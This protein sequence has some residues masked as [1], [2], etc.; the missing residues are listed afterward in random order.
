MKSR[1]LIALSISAATLGC[2][3]SGLTGDPG[4]RGIAPG[5]A[6]QAAQ[7][8]PDIVT[9]FGGAA[10]AQVSSYVRSVGQR[11][12][13]QTGIVTPFTV[14]TLNSPVLNAFAVP[15]GYVYFT[16]DLVALANDEAELASVI[17]HEMGHVA[18]DHAAERQQTSTLGGLGALLAGVIFGS[19]TATQLVGQVA[20]TYLLS[21]SRGQENESDALGVR[22]I[23]AAGYDPHASARFLTSLGAATTLDDQINGRDQRSVPNFARTHPL[24]QERVQ[25]TTTLA[26]QIQNP[27]NERGRDRHL[28]AIDGMIYGDDP[29]QGVIEGNQF[30]HPVL[31][32]RFAVPQGYTMQNGASA[33]SISGP[34]GQ[35]QFGGG[36][37]T[38]SLSS[39]ID[40][41]FRQLTGGQAQV[42][43]PAPRTTTVNGKQA[44][45]TTATLN[46]QQGQVDVTVFAYQWDSSTIYHFVTLTRAGSG[47]GPFSSMIGSLTPL[48][49]SE[50][51][52]IR[53][54]VI[55]IVTVR[56]GDTV[57]S[58]AGRMAYGNYQ[59]ERFLV[60]NGLSSNSQ[61]A[62]G[63][64]VKLVVYGN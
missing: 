22:Y 53:P 50:A 61:L 16:R 5:V 24:S 32:L 7:Q 20:Q 18:A 26:N 64:K 21:Y 43:Y 23:N 63:Q 44:A 56:S 27:G 45:Y 2:A 31:R 54:R 8:H 51:A 57:Q 48:S 28:A 46:A 14:T 19:E 30:L 3:S 52:A 12:A 47:L 40:Q 9:E 33:V 34:N 62:A 11:V 36:R 42:S 15:G 1:L 6:Q 39:H 58:L 25:R 37:S 55:D 60:L 4:S 59:L 35:A 49:A 10:N 41:V 29:Q 38:G 17:G 13:A